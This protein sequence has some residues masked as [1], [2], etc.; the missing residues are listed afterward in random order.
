MF[1][2]TIILKYTVCITCLTVSDIC[3]A[4][5]PLY[6]VQAVSKVSGHTDQKHMTPAL[7]LKTIDNID[8]N[9]ASYHSS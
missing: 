9:L 3:D 2:T 7:H 8:K 5:P 4:N 1:I 6:H